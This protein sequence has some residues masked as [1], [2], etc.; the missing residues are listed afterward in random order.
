MKLTVASFNVDIKEPQDPAL[1]RELMAENG[2]EVW[3]LQEVDQNTRRYDKMY[4][5]DP[6]PGY[7][8]ERYKDAF[9]AK[10]VDFSENGGYGNAV[11]SLYP[12][13]EKEAFHLYSDDPEPEKMR[14]KFRECYKKVDCRKP[15]TL[16]SQISVWGPGGL[17]SRGAVEPRGY[18][19][20]VFEKEGYKIAF[21]F[22]HLTFEKESIRKQQMEVLKEAI[23]N[24]PVPYRILVGDFNADQ[25]TYEFD[26]FLE[27][28]NMANGLEGVWLDTFKKRSGQMKVCS[29]DNIIVSKNIKI[30]NVWMIDTKKL[31]DHRAL[32]ADLE[33][34]E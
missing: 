25:G 2:V 10:A 22:T 17:V 1:Y 8:G 6:L 12:F 9:F 4:E 27:N 14:E 13:L 11:V 16:T 32:A 19:R 5:K 3:G 18:G 30:T 33:F 29:V 20:V 31:S 34:A 24:D 7:C 21:Y 23:S 26:T 28:F 15:L